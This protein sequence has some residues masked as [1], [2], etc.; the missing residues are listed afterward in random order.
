MI[1]IL[2]LLYGIGKDLKKYFEWDVE[3]KLVD[4]QWLDLSGFRDQMEQAGYVL[5]W[6]VE[7]KVES[8]LL[9]G[10]ELVY[11]IEKSRR[12]RSRIVRGPKDNPLILIGKKRDD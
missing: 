5:R 7:D 10:Y 3:D 1:E 9:K 2:G 12:V 8:W 6:S 4:S 11:A